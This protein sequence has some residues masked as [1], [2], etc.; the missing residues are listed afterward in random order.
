MRLFLENPFPRKHGR[1]SQAVIAS[2]DW[3]K[4]AALCFTRKMYLNIYP[5]VTVLGQDRKVIDQH[6]YLIYSCRNR[7]ELRNILFLGSNFESD[8]HVRKPNDPGA[9]E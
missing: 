9:H 5:F 8:I 7:H 6:S 3:L 1:S 4:L 2:S